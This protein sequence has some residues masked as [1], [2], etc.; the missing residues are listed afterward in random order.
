MLPN[1]LVKYGN[2]TN[3]YRLMKVIPFKDEFIFV[4][5]TLTKLMNIIP[6]F[7]AR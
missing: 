7:Q 2:R 5:I 3:T 1:V 6:S 4:V